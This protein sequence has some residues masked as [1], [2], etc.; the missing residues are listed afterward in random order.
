MILSVR[1]MSRGNQDGGMHLVAVLGHLHQRSYIKT[2][3]A[4]IDELFD[5][6]SSG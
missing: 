2:G 4:L 5:M 1:R 6:E 3:K